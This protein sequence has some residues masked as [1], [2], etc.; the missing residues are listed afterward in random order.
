[1]QNLLDKAIDEAKVPDMPISSAETSIKDIEPTFLEPTHKNGC[2][3]C[4]I[5]FVTKK[6]LKVNYDSLNTFWSFI[7]LQF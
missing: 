6:E 2:E 1:M 4:D 3:E 7:Y 5:P